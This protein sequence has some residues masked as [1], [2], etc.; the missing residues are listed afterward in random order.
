MRLQCRAAGMD[1]DHAGLTRDGCTQ[2]GQLHG[3]GRAI[4]SECFAEYFFDGSARS[5][6]GIVPCELDADAL[7]AIALNALAFGVALRLFPA[8]L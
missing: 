7:G 3:M 6:A 5:G 1:K 8:Y 4:R 2:R